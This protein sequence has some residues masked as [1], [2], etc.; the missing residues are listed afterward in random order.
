MLELSCP[1]SSHLLQ[2]R[3]LRIVLSNERRDILHTSVRLIPDSLSLP[4]TLIESQGTMLLSHANIVTRKIV[5][6]TFFGNKGHTEQLAK[7]VMIF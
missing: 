6:S 5:E 1:N 2:I 4:H 7:F 3:H